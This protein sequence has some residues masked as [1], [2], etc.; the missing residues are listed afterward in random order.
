MAGGAA[1]EDDV[2]TGLATRFKNA[3]DE[4]LGDYALTV[5]GQKVYENQAFQN[6]ALKNALF[7]VADGFFYTLSNMTAVDGVY[8]Y[9]TV[10]AAAAGE[11]ENNSYDFSIAVQLKGE[12]VEK[13]QSLAGTLAD[14][15]A[16]E[17]LTADEVRVLYGTT[18]A[19]ENEIFVVTMEMP[20]ALM[21]KAAEIVADKGVEPE[22]VQ[23]TF[24][25][26]S[27]GT[28]LS[29]MQ[30]ITL[31]DVLGSGADEI[32]SVLTTVNSNA[33]VINK[34]LSKMTVSVNGTAFFTEDGFVPGSSGDAYQNFMAGVIG[35]TSDDIKAMTPSQFKSTGSMDGT[36]YA[37]PVTVAVDLDSSM[38][39]TA[40]ETVVVVLHVDFSAY[41]GTN[42]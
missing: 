16:M 9:K 15:L 7:S 5:D 20:D 40:N 36:Y 21:Q 26:A 14:H 23:A 11:G 1:A 42:G 27:V 17:K 38:G 3:L 39:F 34:V 33:N 25:N 29:L 22:Q 37:V 19:G 35:M 13:V 2:L 12:D 8:T 30:G 10:S 32:N 18:V 4:T 28:F 6:T 31:D 41:T 24:D